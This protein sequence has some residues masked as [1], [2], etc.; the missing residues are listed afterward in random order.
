MALGGAKARGVCQG[1]AADLGY[2]TVE[3]PGADL[4]HVSV[5]I[6]QLRHLVAAVECGNLLKA[7]KECNISQSGFSRSIRSLED[8]LGVTLLERLPKGVEPTLSGRELANHARLILNEHARA[9][10]ALNALEGG[11]RGDVT[12]GITQ[13]FGHY[14]VPDFLAGVYKNDPGMRLKVEIGGF[15]DLVERLKAGAIDFAFGLLGPLH[16]DE[17]IDIEPLRRHH[18]RVIAR[19]NHPLLLEGGEVTAEKLSAAR[20]ANLGGEGFQTNFA[21]YFLSHG[22]MQPVQVLKS[23][24][25]SLVRNFIATTDA[26]AVLPPDLVKSDLESGRLAVLDCD[27]P[28][29]ETWVGLLFRKHGVLTGQGERIVDYIRKRLA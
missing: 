19:A 10:E 15:L 1:G 4:G 26:L 17:L 12:F 14:L 6:Q 29:E 7:A 21:H 22:L 8:R 9:M 20:W 13:N 27:A 25:I 2:R 23:E 16:S 18:S 5:E 28:A 24:S 11:K 3:R